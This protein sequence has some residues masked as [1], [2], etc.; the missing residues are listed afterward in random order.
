MFSPSTMRAMARSVLKPA[1]AP[2]AGY[3]TVNTASVC[4]QWHCRTPHTRGAIR[5]A[6]T[7]FSNVQMQVLRRFSDKADE[8]PEPQDQKYIEEF[9]KSFKME[10]HADKFQSWGDL[11]NTKSRELK[12]RDI[13]CKHRKK[14]LA[15]VEFWK[16]ADLMREKVYWQE[17]CAG[18]DP[19][20]ASRL[21]EHYEKRAY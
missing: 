4:R 12:K 18:R 15:K 6:G 7:K 14:I 1:Q 13:P 21:V 20:K 19:F 17:K 16:Q 9:L 2:R 10:E 5:L 3:V 11:V 8:E